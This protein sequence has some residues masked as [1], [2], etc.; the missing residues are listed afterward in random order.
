MRRYKNRAHKISSCNYLSED[1]FCQFA[2][3]TESL[4]S[5]SHLELFSGVCRRSTAAAAHD[6]SLAE[7]D[8]KC[9]SVADRAWITKP[10]QPKLRIGFRKV[11][12]VQLCPTLCNLMDYTVHGI[13]QARILEWGAFPFSRGSS[14]PRDRTQ[15]SRIAGRFFTSWATREA[16][17]K[18]R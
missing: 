2:Q 11:K 15:V 8:S 13:L 18:V 4:I 7:V 1:L 16:L 14:Q 10:P 6:I 12:V 3:N 5:C 17:W 9:Q